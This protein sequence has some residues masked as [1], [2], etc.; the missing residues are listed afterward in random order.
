[1]SIVPISS[2]TLRPPARL[3]GIQAL[4]GLAASAVVLYHVS[5]H[6]N[7]AFGFPA[8][9]T[10][11]HWGHAGV[12]LFFVISGFIILFVHRRD[13]GQP[14]R[15]GHYVGR[16]F[17]RV[18]P[19]YW[20]ALALTVAMKIARG[21]GLPKLFTL[22]WSAT[23]LPS[24][25]PPVLVIAWTLQFEVLFYA[26][27]AVLVINRDV[28]LAVMTAWLGWIAAA[29]FGLGA[30]GVPPALCGIFGLEFFF[31]M[32]IAWVINRHAVR[33]PLV[34]AVMGGSLFL[35][36]MASESAGALDGFG[37][38]AR[39]AYGIP[40]ALLV[41]GIAAAEQAGRLRVPS[42]LET[43][44]G[45]SYSIY[46]FQFVFI[47]LA[48]QAWVR[49]G[50][51]HGAPPLIVFLVLVAAALMGGVAMSRGVEQPLLRLARRQRRRPEPDLLKVG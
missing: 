15:L 14:D 47:G 3:S 25:Q 8:L 22:I 31:G 27:F 33:A 41:M 45:A 23:L 24:I 16:R 34:V 44:G 28:G 18:M 10:V 6:I 2:A 30:A 11:F 36:A 1:M 12:D 29:G 17:N 4:R 37:I 38:A 13:I 35:A 46:L 51:D 50:L 5:R 9:T 42:W 26:V 40:A 20:I 32:G 21:H 49:T 43:L 19:V 39:F 7:E 48:W